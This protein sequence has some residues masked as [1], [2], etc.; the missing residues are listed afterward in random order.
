MARDAEAVVVAHAAERAVAH[1]GDAEA[2]G[3]GRRGDQRPAQHRAELGGGERG[4]V[5][6]EGADDDPPLTSTGRGD[7]GD[8]AETDAGAEHR[9]RAVGGDEGGEGVDERELRR[10]PHREVGGADNAGEV[11]AVGDAWSRTHPE[12]LAP[13]PVLHLAGGED[14]DGKSR[15]HLALQ[16]LEVGGG[17]G[18]RRSV[19]EQGVVGAGGREGRRR[20]E[21]HG[22]AVGPGQ[23]GQRARAPDRR[24]VGQDQQPHEGEPTASGAVPDEE[25]EDPDR[26]GRPPLG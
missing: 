4:T 19:H 2:A 15:L 18:A 6:A 24:A 16:A 8:V 5:A 3:P 1:D 14:D 22:V 12:Q 26:R 20:V 21:G 11:L 10:H 17:A 7:D 9:G 25:R 13:E 23:G